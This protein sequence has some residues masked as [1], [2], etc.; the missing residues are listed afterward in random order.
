M[1]LKQ[2]PT[3]VKFYLK[4]FKNKFLINLTETCFFVHHVYLKNV[5]PIFKTK[6]K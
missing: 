6:F 2:K 5:Y 3:V 4:M 1:S